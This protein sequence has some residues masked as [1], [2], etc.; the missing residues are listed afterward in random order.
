MIAVSRRT[1]LQD[2]FCCIESMP[3][4]CCL[5]DAAVQT[6][7]DPLAWHA[8]VTAMPTSGSNPGIPPSSLMSLLR[9][10]PAIAGVVLAGFDSAFTN[11]L[12]TF[13]VINFLENCFVNIHV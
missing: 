3:G 2:R 8:Q 11:R 13:T 6:P 9:A 4:Q 7:C 10:R 12:V 1:Q 5:Y